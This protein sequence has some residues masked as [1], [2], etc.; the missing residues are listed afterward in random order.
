MT[1][2]EDDLIG[3]ESN[4]FFDNFEVTRLVVGTDGPLQKD[5]LSGTFS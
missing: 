5:L 1:D 2:Q 3:Q 4:I